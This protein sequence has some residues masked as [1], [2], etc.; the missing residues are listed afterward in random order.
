LTGIIAIVAG[1][2]NS[3]ALKEDGT[4]WVWGS[5][6]Y[7][8]IGDGTTTMRKI[9]VK[10]SGISGAIGISAGAYFVQ[11]VRDDGT[12]WG[13]GSNTY[14]QL[15]DGTTTMRT[16]P[17]QVTGVSGVLSVT[18][19]SF[20]ALALK[21]DGT[22]WGW[23]YNT[24]GQLGDG[25]TTTVCR[26]A[27][28]VKNVTGITS[29][30]AG[31][32][33]SH[34]IGNDGSVWGWGAN[35]GGQLGDGT[36]TNRYLPIKMSGVNA[37]STF[38]ETA[39]RPKGGTFGAPVTVALV[40]NEPATI[41]YTTNG[42]DPVISP[43]KI[44]YA[45]PVF[46]PAT[47]TLKYY[48]ADLAGHNEAVKTT[49]YIINDTTPPVTTA[50]HAGGSYATPQTITLTANEPAVIYYTTNGLDPTISATKRIYTGP[51]TLSISTTLKYYAQDL[52]GNNE[53]FSTA[54]F[55]I[56]P[57]VTTIF[58]PGG[59]YAAP[60]SVTLTANQP[61]TIYYTTNGLE[62]T[63][64][65]TVYSGAL[66]VSVSTTLKYFAKVT[67]GASESVKTV[68][69]IIKQNQN[70]TFNELPTARYN[71]PDFTLNASASS[72]LPVNYTSSNT[73]VA[74]V[75]GDIVTIVGA[76]TTII[77]A[78]QG[79]DAS[80]NPAPDVFRLLT[81]N[82]APATIILGDLNTIYD[83]TIKSVSATTIPAGLAVTFT[84]NGL[85]TA[86]TD[87]GTYPIVATVDNANYEGSVTATLTVAKADQT[88]T[89]TALP[90]KMFGDPSFVLSA[91]TSSGLGIS[92]TSS[93][94]SVATVNSGGTVT[95]VG[96][97]T[98][99]ISAAQSGN[100]NYNAAT[101][102]IQTLTVNF[103]QMSDNGSP[104]YFTSI[105]SAYG[106][107]INGTG[108]V[109]RLVTGTLTE[110]VVFDKDF[111]VTLGGG[112]SPSFATQTGLTMLRGSM[113]FQKGTV[114]IDG[115][116]VIL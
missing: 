66:T 104:S 106:T 9:P 65:S 107:I 49:V 110:A 73:A 27:V 98:T 5:N 35:Y 74:T 101:T 83:G 54:N 102:V 19:G 111:T 10:V 76:G 67:G 43:A 61:A 38:P 113:T 42:T 82:K 48:A 79:G 94:T 84:Y 13:W 31:L 86:P 50:S 36:Y 17:V 15:G 40:A 64:A 12:V 91:A 47:T 96:P 20:H 115:S 23:G 78:R 80:Y 63:T 11:A 16:V 95:L 99:T 55:T 87:A 90:G 32:D 51:L 77:T 39:A 57:P 114:I 60:V 33:H 8:Q 3:V 81:V 58:P 7:G 26:T 30:A 44:T 2:H 53:T 25:T 88:I 108:A 70:I 6:L 71:D 24:Y 103:L 116:I 97:G 75:N 56:K 92:Y 72:G 68:V 21:N 34:A 59:T 52:A 62:P 105:S 46:I 93:N 100:S 85:G 29:I 4:V 1:A 28:Q 37:G 22:V 109:I 41:Y 69:Y 89:F 14:G 45:G 112:Y 18:A